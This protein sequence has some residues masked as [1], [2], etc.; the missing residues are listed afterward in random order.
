MFPNTYSVYLHST[1]AH[2]LFNE[3]VRAFSHG[4]IRVSDP[5]ALATYVMRDEPGDWTREKIDVTMHQGDQTVRVNL[6]RHITVLILYG[7]A[8]ATEA[9]PI[10]FFADLY[11]YDR[12]LEQQLGLPPAR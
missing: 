1:P 4:C 2:R 3:S 9:G 8:L 7:T 5:L 12:K 10:Q 6:Q 11:G